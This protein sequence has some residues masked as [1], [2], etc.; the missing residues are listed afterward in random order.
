MAT[1]VE[2]IFR[3]RT[4]LDTPMPNAPNFHRI[5]QQLLTEEMRMMN[6][7]NTSTQ[8]W[9]VSEYQL[10]YTPGTDTY[11]INVSDFGRPILVVRETTNPYVPFIPVPFDQITELRYGTIW[12]G[13]WNSWAAPLVLPE[14][15]EHIAFYRSGANNQQYMCK[16][17]PMPQTSA[18]YIVSYIPG[19]IGAGDPLQT[20]PAL[21]EYQ[22]LIRLRTAA[23][24]LP[25]VKWSENP[26]MDRPRK[27]ELKEAF[28]FQ[29]NGID[30]RSGWE[31]SFQH[32]IRSLVV[33]RISQVEDWNYAS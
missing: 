20:S 29:L 28:G 18:T 26:D 32:Y 13:F 31:A 27:A 9:A 30:G 25:Y 1:R 22:E 19:A 10:N 23:A 15:L 12:N 2:N 7:L 33:N 6:D 3:V 16:I 21:S 14:A 17:Q 4:M 8:P 24:L 11:A 5:F